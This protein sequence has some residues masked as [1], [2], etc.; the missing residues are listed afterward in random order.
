MALSQMQAV[1]GRKFKPN[2][3]DAI[4]VQGQYL[5]SI[6][7]RKEDQAYR[8]KMHGLEEKNLAQREKELETMEALELEKLEQMKKQAKRA[9][10]MGVANLGL[11]AGL[12]I[13]GDKIMKPSPTVADTTPVMGGEATTP[14][15]A[16]SP[17]SWTGKA[18]DWDKWGGA[19]SSWE[20]WAGGVAGGLA[21][22]IFGKDA[23]TT[24]KLAIGAGA[25]ALTSVLTSGA[26][27]YKSIVGGV[28]GGLGGLF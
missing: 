26:D 14:D 22:N 19:A 8:D 4:N 18:T 27:I 5:P 11:Q 2:Y 1:T 28:L 10:I 15:I 13:Y 21:A 12:G 20:P 16:P 24:K 7:A 9:N 25:G 6:Y 3:V 23:G 17:T